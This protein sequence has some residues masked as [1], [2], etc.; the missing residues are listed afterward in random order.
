MVA[1]GAAVGAT[2]AVVGIVVGIAGWFAF[3]PT[4]QSLSGHRVDRFDLPWPAI[5]A[6]CL[7]TLLTAVAAAWWPSRGVSRLSIMAALSGRPPRPQPAHR[8]ATLGGILLAGGIVLLAFGDQ[9]RAGF[10]IGGTAVTAIGILML[11]PLAIGA[12]AAIG[13]RAT[14]SVRL[15][16]RDL[17]RYQA[18]SGAALGSITLA[19]GIAATIT[20]AAAA[21]VTP[22]G[23]GNLASNQMMVYISQNQIPPLTA[24]QQQVLAVS[25]NRMAGYLHAST[26][27]PLEQAYNPQDG[28][29]PAQPGPASNGGGPA[30]Y[31]T[32][33]LAHITTDG[34]RGLN[35]TEMLPFYV[36]TPQLLAHYGISPSQIA[37]TSEF[38]SGTRG[39][40]GLQVFD[41]DSRGGAVGGRLRITS[42]SSTIQVITKLPA[43]T[44]APDVLMTSAGMQKYGFSAL[45][46]G[47]L[48]QSIAP[49]TA[50][51]IN[52][53]RQVAARAGLVIESRK[54]PGSSAAVQNW[55]TAAGI[56]L[57]LG[58]LA[59]TV[60][61]IRSETANDLRTLSATGASSRTRR[62]V[63]A[64]TAG[65][66]A[67]LGGLLGTAG[68]Y[69]ALLAWYRSNL[70]PLDQVPALNLVIIIVGLPGI[71]TAAGWLLAGRQP[72]LIGRR[73]LE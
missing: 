14:I 3:V 43:F 49:M 41:P 27:L 48:I 57:A 60:G 42:T 59:M 16:V 71:A 38:I 30:G 23:P 53:A 65:S 64:A 68:A 73:P 4:L 11:A 61:L 24:A 32:A 46:S 35:I 50:A 10:I 9:R 18:R 39:L 45:F 13:P 1:N 56:L 58:V 66:L 36:A 12:L 40:T 33:T 37:P 5:A 20:I 54:A 63:T 21:S 72:P 69:A 7:L 19:I 28:E 8:F 22:T 17:A 70:N 2:A 31:Q 34:S 47:W 44:S 26:I 52:S 15:A 55:S 6:A 29:A 25:V 67:L 62:N 51:E